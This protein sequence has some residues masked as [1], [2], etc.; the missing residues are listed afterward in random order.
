MAARSVACTL[1]NQTGEI[2]SFAD[3]AL[4]HGIFTPQQAPPPVCE[5]SASWSGESDGFMTGTEGRV[6]Y[7]GS[8]GAVTLYWDNPFVGGNEYGATSSGDYVIVKLQGPS[9]GSNVSA[10]YV[11]DRKNKPPPAPPPEPPAPPPADPPPLLPATPQSSAP[12]QPGKDS[13]VPKADGQLTIISPKEWLVDIAWQAVNHIEWKPLVLEITENRHGSQSGATCPK[14]LP[15]FPGVKESGP[16]RRPHDEMASAR[17]KREEDYQSEKRRLTDSGTDSATAE[18][19]A[20]K[21]FPPLTNDFHSWCGDF[22]TWV[23]WKAWVLRGSPE[24][25]IAKSE[26]GKFLNREA[27]NGAWQPGENL[28]MVEAYAKGL[29]LDVFKKNQNAA[30]SPNGLMV[31]HPPGDGY[32]PKPGDIFMANR[33]AGG[34]ISIVASAEALANPTPKQGFRNFMTIDG[35]SFDEDRENG[36]LPTLAK[37]EKEGTKLDLPGGKWQGVSQTRRDVQASKDPLRGFIDTAKLRE[38][39]GYR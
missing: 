14:T 37:L 38:A 12:E 21:K 23:F 17:T 24:D 33:Q 34:H 1:I 8:S 26:L 19:T 28:T 31:W 35:K 13:H 4:D 29:A 7:R 18:Q 20:R 30:G 9:V 2:L 27:L 3:A 32:V 25:K 6:V 22:V 11:V 10:T 36:W 39:L 16:C 5:G 15:A